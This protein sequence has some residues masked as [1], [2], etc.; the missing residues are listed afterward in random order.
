MERLT[1]RNQSGEAYYPYCFQENTCAG[2]GSSIKCGKCKHNQDI[3]EK[4]AEYEDLEEEGKLI[5][6]LCKP[7]DT[8]WYVEDYDVYE[9]TFIMAHDNYVMVVD[10]YQ[11]PKYSE[12]ILAELNR[13][14]Y[15]GCDEVYVFEKDKV[16]LTREDAEK[17]IE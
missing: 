6:L 15:L 8:V 17:Y 10:R 9:Y 1:Q 13:K 7:G 14:E 2:N 4:L 11:N 3:C 5:K 16:F 12:H